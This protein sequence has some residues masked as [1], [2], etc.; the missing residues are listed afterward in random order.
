MKLLKVSSAL[1]YALVQILKGRGAKAIGGDSSV[2]LYNHAYA[3]GFYAATG[4]NQLQN[5]GAVLNKTFP[6]SKYILRKQRSQKTLHRN[7]GH[8]CCRR[9]SI[10]YK[11][12]RNET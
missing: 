6:Q 12:M 1:M 11:T 3:N 2:G 10:C 4:M 9:K 8:E 7:G 5:V